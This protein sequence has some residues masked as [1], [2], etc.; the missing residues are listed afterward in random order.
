[1][2]PDQHPDHS[3]ELRRIQRI[4]GQL[5][6]VKKMIARRRYC[7]D[8]LNQTKAVSSAIHSLEASLLEKHLQHCVSSALSSSEKERQEKIEELLEIFQKRLK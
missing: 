4:I 2:P 7:I 6:G 3:S 1:M 5:E 8:I